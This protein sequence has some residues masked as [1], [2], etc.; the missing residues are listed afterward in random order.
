MVRTTSAL[1]GSASERVA[2]GEAKCLR[3]SGIGPPV[4]GLRSNHRRRWHH[5][6]V[7][8]PAYARFDVCRPPHLAAE[9]WLSVE[10]ELLRLAR[11]LDAADDVQVIG[12]A[13]CLVEAVAK[14]VWDINGTPPDSNDGFPKVVAR[15]HELLRNQPGHELAHGTTFANLAMQASKMAGY[16]AEIRNSL[17]GGHG[18]ARQPYVRAEEVDLALDGAL[19]WVRWA[20]RRIGLFAEGCQGPAGTARRRSWDVPV[21][22]HVFCPVMA[23]RT[24]QE[25]PSVRWALGGQVRGITP[26]PARAWVRRMLS[27]LVWQM[28]AWCSS[29]STVAV[30]RVLGI[31]SSNEA[32]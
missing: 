18:R 14:I 11:S 6:G 23:T 21:D 1:R 9:Y 17:G 29:L 26:V 22:G 16:L 8:E 24:A 12:D 2:A 25:W 32:G 20:L 13:K 19:T 10:A 15:A 4:F 28:W 7:F 30:A 3:H 31:S 5:L 27:P